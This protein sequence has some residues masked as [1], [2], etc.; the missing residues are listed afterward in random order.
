VNSAVDDEFSW[1]QTDE[2]EMEIDEFPNEDANQ[3][4]LDEESSEIN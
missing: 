4:S 1:D 2:A 3:I